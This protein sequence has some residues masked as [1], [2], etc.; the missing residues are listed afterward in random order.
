MFHIQSVCGL[1]LG[2][3]LV[4]LAGVFRPA[5]P[6]ATQYADSD[7]A[8]PQIATEVAASD[9]APVQELAEENAAPGT[10]TSR[11]GGETPGTLP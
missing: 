1:I 6:P 8:T 4:I 7:T 3:T 11:N 5:E 2:L 10:S 9:P